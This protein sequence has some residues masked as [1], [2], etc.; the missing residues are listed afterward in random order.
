[1]DPSKRLNANS[2]SSV[3]GNLNVAAME[4]LFSSGDIAKAVSVAVSYNNFWSQRLV[5]EFGLKPVFNAQGLY[6]LALA[7]TKET[8]LNACMRVDSKFYCDNVIASWDILPYESL[9]SVINTNKVSLF[10][11]YS[12]L[13]KD[14][15]ENNLISLV[16][17]MRKNKTNDILEVFLSSQESIKPYAK[18]L[19]NS[20]LPA[21][22]KRT[23][24]HISGDSVRI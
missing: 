21:V 1:M 2:F 9:L 3:V 19:K 16:S 14:M 10:K 24:I 18:I 6:Y 5:K 15:S 22:I 20:L 13:A 12:S 7:N 11:H 8:L 4:E 23:E 17:F